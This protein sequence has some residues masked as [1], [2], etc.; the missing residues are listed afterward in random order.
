MFGVTTKVIY[1][2][3]YMEELLIQIIKMLEEEEE[4]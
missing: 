2:L 4:R 3:N 1:H